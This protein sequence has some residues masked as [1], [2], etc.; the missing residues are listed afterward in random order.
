[1]GLIHAC[2]QMRDTPRTTAPGC[3]VELS[4]PCSRKTTVAAIGKYKRF[5]AIAENHRIFAK[6]ENAGTF[7]KSSPFSLSDNARS[8]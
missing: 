6:P 8:N 3:L 5:M 2:S 7:G 4:F 1:M